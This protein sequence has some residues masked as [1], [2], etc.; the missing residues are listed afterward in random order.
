MRDLVI[1][2]TNRNDNVTPIE[3]I[4]AIKKAG[5]K[6]VFI[7]WYHKDWEISKEEQLEYINKQGLNVAFAHLCY[8][9]INCLWDEGPQGDE[10][11]NIYKNDIKDLSEKNISMVIMHLTNG[12]EAP[13]YG[14][15]GINRLKNLADY[16]KS[17][18]MKIAFENTKIRGYLEYVIDNIKNDN[19]G[20]CFDSGHYHTHFKDKLDFEKFK[21]RIFAIHLHDNDQSKDQHLIPFDGTINWEDLIQKIKECNY[22]GAVTIEACARAQYYDID[23]EE[24]YRRCYEAG[25]KLQKMFED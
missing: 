20:I 25:Q 6:N 12:F 4:D 14:E 3:T 18:N 9:R 24:F 15:I 2:A 21:D 22:N 17:L 1:V 19:V 11:V 5:F 13:A 10:L 7:Q 16:A 23:I 8:D